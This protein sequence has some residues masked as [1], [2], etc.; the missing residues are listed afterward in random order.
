[1]SVIGQPLPEA[2]WRGSLGDAVSC[3]RK[4]S[5][6]EQ[7]SEN[8]HGRFSLY[9]CEKKSLE[10]SFLLCTATTPNKKNQSLKTVMYKKFLSQLY[11]LPY[12]YINLKIIL[13]HFINGTLTL[14]QDLS[15]NL[16][17]LERETNISG[18]ECGLWMQNPGPWSQKAGSRHQD[19]GY[20]VRN[21]D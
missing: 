13:I 3:N 11:P 21:K 7:W 1:M 8:K 19:L 9:L 6:E 18:L 20:S 14:W 10:E 16:C 5:W 12:F 15:N 4:K 2:S 17:S